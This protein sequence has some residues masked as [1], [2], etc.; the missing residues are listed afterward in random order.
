MKTNFIENALNLFFPPA[1]GMCGQI[2]ASY[3]CEYCYEYLKTRAK[4][5]L[6]SYDDKYFSKHFWIFEYKDEIREKIIDYKFNDKSYL[7]RTF[8]E[9]ILNNEQAIKYIQSF[10]IIIPVPI[11]KKRLKTRGY[12][13]CELI[14]KSLCKQIDNVVYRNDLII[15]VNNIKP[16]STLTKIERAEN[17][18]GAY[19]ISKP[20]ILRDR[21]ILLIDDIYTTGSTVNECS[22]ILS[23]TNC[24]TIGVF[25]L[26]KD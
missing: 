16:Q 14:S 21:K 18:I 24:E 13:Q 1:C 7:Y 25:S 5:R 22:K 9:I 12:N 2:S 8:L 10:D 4:N 3:I 26:A 11:H 6:D 23:E 20:E 15:K 19:E 17:I